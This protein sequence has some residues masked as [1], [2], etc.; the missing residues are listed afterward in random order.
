MVLTGNSVVD[1]ILIG[2]AVLGSLGVIWQKFIHPIM[3]AAGKVNDTLPVLVQI[4]DEFRPNNGHSLHDVITQMRDDGRT[5]TAYAHDAKHQTVNRL[6]VVE[7]KQALLAEQVDGL[8]QD[9][10]GIMAILDRRSE[11]R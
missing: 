9:V 4:A 10:A 5:L 7:C 8:K 2:A 6:I 3:R 11:P 1:A